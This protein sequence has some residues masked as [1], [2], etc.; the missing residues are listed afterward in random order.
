MRNK[1]RAAAAL[2]GSDWRV[3]AGAWS[4]LL[5]AGLGLRLLPLRRVQRLLGAAGGRPPAAGD[6]L[7]AVSR[8][9]RLVGVAAR[10]HLLPLHCLE[11]ALVLQ[12]LL[13]RRGIATEL[14]IGV[15]REGGALDAHAWLERAGVPLGEPS[16]TRERYATLA[17][18]EALI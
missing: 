10:N 13:R 17:A 16:S 14:R 12:V 4:L 11:R 9:A 18:R 3:L 2:S 5:A 15:R 6:E 7:G 8:L 1:L